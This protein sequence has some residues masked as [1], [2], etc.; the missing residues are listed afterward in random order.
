LKSFKSFEYDD[1]KVDVKVDGMYAFAT[2]TY[3]YIII[4]AKDNSEIKHKGVSTSVLKK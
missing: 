3:N 1:Y 2:E 4:S